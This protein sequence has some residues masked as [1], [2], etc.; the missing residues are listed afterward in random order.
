MGSERWDG[1]GLYH[2]EVGEGLP[3]LLI[4]PSGSTA[5]TWGSAVDELARIER[6]TNRTPRVF[7]D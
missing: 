5:S 1:S 2:E 7:H 3:I 4:H 6:V